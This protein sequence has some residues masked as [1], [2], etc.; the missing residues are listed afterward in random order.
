MCYAI[1]SFLR[2]VLLGCG[3]ILLRIVV[4]HCVNL[5]RHC[6]V[7]EQADGVLSSAA[8][9]RGGLWPPTPPLCRCAEYAVDPLW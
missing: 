6:F 4:R 5:M 1:R 8:V 7:R 3:L 9:L 2:Y